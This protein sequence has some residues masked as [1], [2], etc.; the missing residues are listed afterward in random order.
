MIGERAIG[1]AVVA[2]LLVGAGVRGYAEEDSPGDL[3]GHAIY[4]ETDAHEGPVVVP[5]QNRL[6]FTS[7]PDFA[8]DDT[9]IAI[10]YVDLGTK[11]VETFI[12]DANMANGMWLSSDGAALLVAEQGT[13]DTPAAISRISL[14]DGERE[15]IVDS[16]EGK[17]FNSPNKVIEASSG[18]IYF[19]DPDYGYHQG[20]KDA[21]QLPMAVYAHSPETN[22]TTRL[23]TAVARPHGLALSLDENVLYIGDTDAIDGS[24]PYD[25]NRSHSILSAPLLAPNEIGPLMEVLAVPVGIPD[26][27]I[28]TKPHGNLWVA[29]GDGVRLYSSDGMLIEMFPI[30]RGA[31]NVARHGD[32][33]YST[34]DTAIW[35]TRIDGE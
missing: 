25:P 29:A 18:W 19:S 33:V 8:A 21:P 31:F 2:G 9:H 26:G 13:K 16:Y 22:E 6:Y 35:R 20:F 1:V 15:I 11:Q 24:S 3:D 7:V 30:D 28:V 23:T 27:F 4:V 5:D 14:A 17:P 32:T 12:P 10:R 34:A